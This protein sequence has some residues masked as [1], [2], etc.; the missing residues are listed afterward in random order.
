[1]V[2]EME[3]KCL[4]T[5]IESNPEGSPD[6]IVGNFNLGKF[7]GEVKCI[8]GHDTRL[9]NIGRAHFVACDSCRTF[10]NVGS[11]LM[12]SWRSEDRRIWQKNQDSIEGY[13][14]ID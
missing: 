3:D 13:E 1:M 5:P 7:F 14:L 2:I 10:I 11:N 9:F 8:H 6:R 4:H 12:S